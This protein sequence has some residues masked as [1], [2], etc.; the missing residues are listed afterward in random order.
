MSAALFKKFTVP[1][2]IQLYDTFG[3]GLKNGRGMHMCGNSVHLHKALKED[4]RI[5][6]FDIFGYLVEPEVAARNLSGVYLWGN[7]DPMLMLNGSR[8]EVKAAC[9]HCLEAM[10][11]GGGLL[12]GDGANVCPGTPLENLAVFTEAAEE[13]GL[14]S[15][16]AH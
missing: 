16:H 9:M 11:P 6:S 8:D 13:Y 7:V 10:A 3:A 5:S 1:Y 15:D 2:D 12:L 14:P 4:L